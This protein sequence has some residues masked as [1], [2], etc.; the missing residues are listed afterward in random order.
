MKK[1]LLITVIFMFAFLPLTVFGFHTC[2]NEDEK[3]QEKDKGVEL[4]LADG[5]LG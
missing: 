2:P 5:Y 4:G 3:K 1:N